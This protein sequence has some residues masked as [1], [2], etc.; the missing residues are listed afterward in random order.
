MKSGPGL[1]TSGPRVPDPRPGVPRP[2]PRPG[3]PEF[4]REGVPPDFGVF[5][6]GT[7]L[8]EEPRKVL[9]VLCVT[10]DD[11]LSYTSHLS[12]RMLGWWWL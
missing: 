9:T 7:H 11:L 1:P 4:E 2:D 3:V 5:G 6:M 8:A 12:F 10:H